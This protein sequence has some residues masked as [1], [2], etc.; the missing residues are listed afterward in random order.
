MTKSQSRPRKDASDVTQAAEPA[1]CAYAQ[2]RGAK[3]GWSGCVPLPD[4]APA[5]PFCNL[6]FRRLGFFWDVA[7]QRGDG[8]ARG[9]GLKRS[10]RLVLTG[11]PRSGRA[12][13]HLGFRDLEFPPQAAL[14]FQR[15][16]RLHCVL[17]LAL[18]LALTSIAATSLP[19]Q[20]LFET[21]LAT[22]I[23]QTPIILEAPY[24]FVEVSRILTDDF[25]KRRADS[26][27]AAPPSRLLA[28]FIPKLAL[29][30]QLLEKNDRYRSLQVQV[31]KEMERV[32]Y[33]P[34][35]LQKLRTDSTQGLATIAEEDADTVFHVLDLSQFEKKAGGLKIL[36]TATLGPDS[37][38]LLIARSTE[39]RDQ[40]G[41]RQ[42]EASVSCATY[43]L[44]NQKILLL[45]VTG[46][47]LS[48]NELGNTMRLTRE[49]IKLLR[50]SNNAK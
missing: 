16:R 23:D 14:G 35:D 7:R 49:W 34:A 32:R 38:T 50:E 33:A 30:N 2:T 21:Q 1:R 22:L 27:A 11:C 41:G 10:A 45:S 36:G 40:L 18:V 39:G 20:S 42:I 8:I 44:I 13:Q 4:E 3:F 12:G 47:E 37:F 43:L 26:L 25:A 31:I 6:G 9:D 19:A 46:I 29:R 15:L 48:A 17:A 28:W 24:P 5:S